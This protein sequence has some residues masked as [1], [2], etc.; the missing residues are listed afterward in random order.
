MGNGQ[1][2]P[3]PFEGNSES[4]LSSQIQAA[5]PKFPVT[6]PPVSLGCLYAIGAALEPNASKRMGHTWES[7]THHDFFKV[8]DFELLEQKHIEPVFVPSSEKTNFDATYDLEELLL[9][10]APLEARAR[11]QKPREKL[12]GDAS[13][14][15]IREDTLYRMIETD[16]QPFDYTVAAYKKWVA[17]RQI[18]EGTGIAGDEVAQQHF[19]Q[20]G[21]GP[22]ITSGQALT[23]NEATPAPATPQQHFHQQLDQK[24]QQMSGVDGRPIRPLRPAPPLPTAYQHQYTSSN[25]TST[26]VTSPTGGLQVT[27]DGG[28]SWSELARQDATLPSDANH[29][30]AGDDGKG[31]GS[32]GM[33]GFL[34]GKKGRTHS[35]RPKERGVLGKEGAR[36][37]I[38]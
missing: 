13:E 5:N 22:E 9:E 23:T 33:F 27:L 12:K 28:G 19:Q 36:V 25:R 20:Q 2:K 29:A 15:E 18:T 3:R 11:R 7:F 8:F 21:L 30:A 37:V 31:E 26:R 16:F 35:P 4:T 14:K 24:Q 32:G 1:G 34:K 10:E 17:P 6:N 38:G